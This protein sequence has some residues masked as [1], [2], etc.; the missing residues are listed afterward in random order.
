MYRRTRKY[1][2][3]RDRHRPDIAPGDQRPPTWQPP[4]L[5]RRITIEDFDDAEPTI[6][7]IELFRTRRIDSYRAVV[8]GAEWHAGIGW[9]RVLDGLR[10]A[11]PRLLS[12]RN[13]GGE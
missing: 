5:R 1:Q 7:T 10:R 13:N 4:L 11:L 8:N 9:S 12:P 6:H 2:A 3:R